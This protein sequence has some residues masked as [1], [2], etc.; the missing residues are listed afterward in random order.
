MNNR[1]L[2]HA[3]THHIDIGN[4][5]MLNQ[6]TNLKYSLIFEYDP[7]IRVHYSIIFR[8]GTF[9]IVIVSI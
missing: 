2:K 6:Y 9:G 5:V 4:Y 1:F 7:F 8:F 3:L